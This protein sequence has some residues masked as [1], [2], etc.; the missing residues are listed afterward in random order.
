MSVHDN[1]RSVDTF[2]GGD[3]DEFEEESSGYEDSDAHP[4]PIAESDIELELTSF[5]ALSSDFNESDDCD[6]SQM[7]L[8]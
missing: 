3:R 5:S 4:E 6:V 8:T 2:Y 1:E 7:L